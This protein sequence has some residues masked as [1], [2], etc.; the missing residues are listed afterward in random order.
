MVT[1]L[2][3]DIV[4]KDRGTNLI[5]AYKSGEAANTQAVALLR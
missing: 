4:P 2:D 5:F 1:E 3:S